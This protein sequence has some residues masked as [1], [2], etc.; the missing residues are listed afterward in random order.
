M[1]DTQTIPLF[2]LDVVLFPGMVLPL[3]IF[4][5]RYRKMVQDCTVNGGGFGMV[6][7]ES[8]PVELPLDQP[9]IGT[10]AIITQVE[11]LPDGRFNIQTV[12]G[13]RFRVRNLSYDEPYLVGHIEPF[14]AVDANSR[15]AKR[16]TPPLAAL[17]RQYLK[18]LSEALGQEIAVSQMPVDAITLAFVVAILYQCPNPTK[19]ELLS[20]ESI[21]EMMQKEIEILS[22]ENAI[23]RQ[24]LTLRNQGALPVLVEGSLIAW[25][26]N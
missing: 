26:L 20:I 5:P 8:E 12:G 16:L 25:S 23:I 2:P 6:W 24:A 17:L 1:L 9:L 22:V 4:E 14:P 3:H 7:T 19:Q 15:E 10:R 13:E 18:L 21:P 11:P